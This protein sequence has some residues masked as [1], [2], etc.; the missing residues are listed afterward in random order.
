MNIEYIRSKEIYCVM[1]G[2]VGHSVLHGYA[3]HSVLHGYLEHIVL[4][5][6]V[7]EFNE[8]Q[9]VLAN[10]P[11]QGISHWELWLFHRQA[12]RPRVQAPIALIS[13]FV[14]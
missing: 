1:H 5:G 2:C 9:N 4:H 7:T 10:A 12:K 3:E 6:Y 8:I 14:E 13:T 11:G